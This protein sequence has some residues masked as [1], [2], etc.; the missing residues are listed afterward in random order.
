MMPR[1]KKSGKSL[2]ELY[3]EA[4]NDLD[5]AKKRVEYYEGKLEPV[6]QQLIAELAAM[7]GPLDAPEN[8]FD[9]RVRE[10]QEAGNGLAEGRQF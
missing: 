8:I 3:Q 9:R 6:R 4:K 2:A 1:K 10:H 7:G 5:E